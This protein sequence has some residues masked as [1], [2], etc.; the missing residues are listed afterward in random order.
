MKDG[1]SGYGLHPQVGLSE[2]WALLSHLR[3]RE[4]VFSAGISENLCFYEKVLVGIEYV[5]LCK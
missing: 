4:A 3:G 2:G 5:V 1:Q